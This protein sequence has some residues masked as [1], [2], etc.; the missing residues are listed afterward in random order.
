MNRGIKV[1][2]IIPIYN[3]S[4]YLGKCLESVCNQTLKEIEIICINDGSTDCSI[5]IINQFAEHDSRILILNRPNRGAGISR[6]EAISC[7]N[8]EYLGFVDSDD[9]IELD[10][11]EQ[12]YYHS[13]YLDSDLTIC[14]F[15]IFNNEKGNSIKPDWA[16]LPIDDSFQ[17]RCF[18]WKDVKDNFFKLHVGPTNKLYKRDFIKRIDAQFGSYKALEDYQFALTCILNASK[19]AI[20]KKDLYFYRLG[21]PES[22]SSN[23]N[24]RNPFNY[25]EVIKFYR[26]KFKT[27]SNFKEAESQI[28]STII[29]NCLYNLRNIHFSLREEYYN[30]IKNEIKSLNFESN[31]YLEKT[32]IE[33]AQFIKNEDYIHSK[34]NNFPTKSEQYPKQQ[35]VIYSRKTLIK[36]IKYVMNWLTH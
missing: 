20:L 3:T 23:S 19:I 33:D 29:N 1:S 12:L 31:P 9:W 24:S 32:I 18:T 30:R 13:K 4:T 21:V 26:D 22:L 25:F 11:F 2:I 36:K 28:I 5:D 7:A 6:N 10:M 16:I 35:L 15:K 17:D 27:D 14:E 8:G 34:Y